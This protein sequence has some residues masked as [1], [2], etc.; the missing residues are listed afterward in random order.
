MTTLL[1]AETNYEM[2]KTKHLTN[3]KKWNTNSAFVAII[4]VKQ[5]GA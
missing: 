4:D 5:F 3:V 1:F 2:H